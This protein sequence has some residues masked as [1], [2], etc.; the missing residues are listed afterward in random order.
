MKIVKHIPFIIAI[1]FI[2]SAC[3]DY[4]D[5]EAKENFEIVADAYFYSKEDYESAVVGTYD[6]LQWMYLNVLIGDIA[7]E[8]S[9][10]GGESATDVIG[11]QEIDEMR[12]T[13]TNDNLTS[14]WRFLYEGINRANY[15]EENKDKLEFDGKEALYGEVYFLR[16]YYYFELVKF[17]G[18]VPL[19]TERRL[20]ATDSGTLERAS[21]ADVYAQIELDLLTAISALPNTQSQ[22]GRV[23][24]YAAQAL[25]GK[26]YL[27]QDKFAESAS[28]LENVIGNYSLVPNYQDQFL[29]AGENGPE[30]VFEVQY[31]N[32]SEWYDWDFVPQGTEGNFGVIH[33]GPRA[34]S[35]PEYATGWSFNLPTPTLVATF[36]DGD[37]RKEASILDI[38]A[39]AAETGASYAEGY[40]HTGY[41]NKKYI[42]RAGESGAQT[43]LNYLT[44]YRAIRYADV[45]L[46]AAEAN[47]RNGNDTKALDYLNQV[48]ERAFGNTDHNITASGNTL[49]QL[50]WEQRNLE[51]SMEG[52]HFFDLV[53]TNQ[54]ANVIEGFTAGKHEVFPIP[55]QEI[56]I[57]GLTQN[58]G[59]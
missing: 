49:T 30:S 33:N 27:F 22:K 53:R 32:D 20:T 48:V 57:S 4:V 21:K 55:Q 46:M 7:S 14:I 35:G 2:S 24:K 6:P 51:L 3:S 43:E 12:H 54:A 5:Y 16:A 13:P 28:M 1:L 45:L 23:T 10:S 59:Y 25:L 50:I 37:S 11:I 42:P 44:N 47:N 39:F 40:K 56:D 34:F 36:D 17:F 8:N 9:F 26:V 18:D 52:H 31:S 41:Y 15:L 38:E 58:P 19:F 29:K